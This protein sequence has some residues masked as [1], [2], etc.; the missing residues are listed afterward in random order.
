MN[1]PI[2]VFFVC[3][4]TSVIRKGSIK[5]LFRTEM[6]TQTNEPLKSCINTHI[7]SD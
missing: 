7:L 6:D 3:Y 1:T 4:L 2:N 5:L